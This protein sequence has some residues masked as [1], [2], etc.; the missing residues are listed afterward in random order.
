LGRRLDSNTG[1]GSED[2]ASVRTGLVFSNFAAMM[3]QQARERGKLERDSDVLYSP[4]SFEEAR[5]GPHDRLTYD[6][7]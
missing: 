7:T 4:F 6:A 3:V 1:V 2:S 5:T